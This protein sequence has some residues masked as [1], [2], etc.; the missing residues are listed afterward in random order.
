M[1]RMIRSVVPVVLVAMALGSVVVAQ[2]AKFGAPVTV[3]TATPVR[4]LYANPEKFVGKTIRVDGVVTSVCTEMG[5]WVAVKDVKTDQTVRFQADHDGK[6]VFP[7]ALKGKAGSFQGEF[8]KIGSNDTE[9]HEAAAE[10]AHAEP[11]NA[12]FGSRYQIQVSGW[13]AVTSLGRQGGIQ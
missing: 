2:S 12:D 3:S 13:R 4:E 10:H 5:C 8:V 11:K 1:R 6:I 7:I 9:A